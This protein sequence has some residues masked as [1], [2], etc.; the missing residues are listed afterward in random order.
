VSDPEVPHEIRA[1]AE[2]R[3]AARRAGDYAS[4][5]ALRDRIEASGFRVIDTPD[6]WALEPIPPPEAVGPEV[7]V[8]ERVPSVL[9]DPPTA[10]VSLHWIVEGWPE[11]VRRGIRSFDAWAGGR[12]LHHVVVDTSGGEPAGWPDRA[13]VVRVLPGTGW[14]AARNAG[15]V[16]SRGRIA[17]VVDG[18]VEAE[19]DPLEPL[20]AALGDPGVGVTGPFGIVSDDLREFRETAGPDCDA[21]EGYL[22]AFRRELLQ[23][24]VRFDPKFRFYRSADIE[25]SFQVKAMGLRATVTPVPVIRHEHRMWAATPADERARLSKRNFYRFLDRWRGRSDLLVSRGGR[26][27]AAPGA[28]GSEEPTG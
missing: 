8:P 9:E 12:S 13:E 27:P 5:D 21:V 10:D 3:E 6:G 4:A 1:L 26:E 20:E 11:D 18:S 14:G 7:V 2:R 17:V 24:G 16:R 19:G 28:P 25:F 22:M 23:R 15:L